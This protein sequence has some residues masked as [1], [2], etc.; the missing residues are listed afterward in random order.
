MIVFTLTI[1]GDALSKCG[2]CGCN[3]LG[4]NA[5]LS[6]DLYIDELCGQ[7]WFM[8]DKSHQPERGPVCPAGSWRYQ[9]KPTLHTDQV[10]YTRSL[11]EV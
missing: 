1:Y 8:W 4:L 7:I 3:G 11:D 10:I 9:A 5:Q 6:F 2:F